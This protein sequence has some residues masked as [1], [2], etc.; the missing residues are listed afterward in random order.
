MYFLSALTIKEKNVFKNQNGVTV[1]QAFRMDLGDP[2]VWFQV[3]SSITE[4]LEFSELY[5]I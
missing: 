2:C 5:K 1:A 4:K 3:C